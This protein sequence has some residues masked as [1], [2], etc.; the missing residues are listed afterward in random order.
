MMLPK[1][2]MLAVALIQGLCL[3]LIYQRAELHLWPATAPVWLYTLVALFIIVPTFFL[4]L[5]NDNNL[6][7]SLTCLIPVTL[8]V[9]LVSAWSGLQLIPEEFVRNDIII[10][11]FIFTMG[12]ASFKALMYAQQYSAEAPIIY[13][14]LFYSSWRNFLT[15]GLSFLFTLLFF[16]ILLLCGL[17]FELIKIDFFMKLLKN[18]WFFFPAGSMAFTFAIIIFRSLSKIIDSIS[19]LLKALI[20]FLLPLLTVVALIFLAALLFQG[21]EPLWQTSLGS[22]L[23]LWLQAAILF[24]VNAVYQGD[25]E[26]RPYPTL[27]HRAIYLGIGILPVYS[28]IA[29]Y[30]LFTRIGQYGLTVQRCWAVFVALILFFFALG[31]LWSI[32]RNKDNWLE[33]LAWVNIRMGLLIMIMMILVNSPVA[34]FQK[35][36]VQNQIERLHS[37]TQDIEQLDLNYFRYGLGRQGYLALQKVKDEYGLNDP[38]LVARID[39]VYRDQFMAAP[40]MT[41]DTMRE[42]LTVWPDGKSMPDAILLSML[43]QRAPLIAGPVSVNQAPVGTFPA[44]RAMGN[45]IF[46]SSDDLYYGIFIE[47]NSQNSNENNTEEIIF[48]R[49]ALGNVLFFFLWT[50]QDDEWQS[51]PLNNMSTIQNINLAETLE[52]N[53][54]NIVPSQW[55][56]VEIGGIRLQVPNSLNRFQINNRFQAR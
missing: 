17:L 39:A 53:Q 46:L 28:L 54:V 23:I 48:I 50:Y 34:N 13:P 43:D 10:F 19:T 51:I 41:L 52:N 24:S 42:A 49:E 55:N 47:M 4:L 20:K 37:G 11:P 1:P 6:K 35:L 8:I 30:G 27:V 22:G 9:A 25:S 33:G 32:I 44:I 18:E 26:E 14:S 2:L 29:L 56:D 15:L 21:I 31:Y 45:P 12:I 7:K 38:S 5:V 40:A 16:G 3:C 36:S